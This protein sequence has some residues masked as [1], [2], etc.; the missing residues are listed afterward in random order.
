MKTEMYC[1]LEDRERRVLPSNDAFEKW[2]DPATTAVLEIDMHRGHVGPE[3]ALPLPVP[4]ARARV[5]QHDAFQAAAR[6]LGVPIIHVQH[7]QRHGGID[8]ANSRAHNSGAN[9]RVLYDLYLPPNELMLEH[10]WEGTPWLD[11]I[12]EDVEGDY[13]I[14]TKKRLSAFY[15]TD[16][17]FLLRQL[18]V[19]NVVLT[20]TMTDACVL[21]TAF[22]AANRD[23]RVIIPRD[24]VAGY[25]DEAEHGALMCVSLHAGL[26]VDGPALLREWAGRVGQ[27][28]PSWLEGAGTMMDAVQSAPVGA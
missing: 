12:T 7:W 14:R 27:T 6:D 24:I 22:D 26:V 16:L 17:E 21:S 19:T 3:E 28:L 15:P 1:Y 2:L 10:S 9:W 4:R 5:A 13:Y 11:L 23:L 20:G 25:N 8:D 18:G